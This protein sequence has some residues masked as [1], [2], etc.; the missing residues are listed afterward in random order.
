[1]PRRRRLPIA[2]LLGL[3]VS[4][5][6]AG[7]PLPISLTPLRAELE[8]AADFVYTAL[9]RQAGFLLQQVQPWETDPSLKL[10]TESRSGEHW[11][12]P[13][14]GT[15]VGL[16]AL[17]R[18][19][20][21]DAG[22]VGVD[23]DEVLTDYI[24]PMTRY[25]VAT[26][27]TG[28]RP[29]DDG[30]PWGD[31]W[32]SALWTH[33]LAR[34]A[35]FVWDDLP[36]DLRTGVRR[37]VAHE[38]DRFVEAAPPHALRYDTKAEENA[39]N[40]R[41][42]SAAVFLMPNDKRR[43]AWEQ[44]FE[45]WSMSSFLR[46]SDERCETLVEGKPVSD[47]F[48]GANV[49]E[50]FT[51]ENHGFVHPGYMGCIATTLG[52]AVDFRLSGRSAP[53]TIAWNAHELYDNLKWMATVDGNYV[54]PSGQDWTLFRNPQK[55][56]LHLMMAAFEGD[57]DGWSLAENSWDALRRMQART[58]EGRVFLDSEY[59][60][61]SMQHDTLS[62]L[63]VQWIAL[64]LADPIRDEPTAR[65]GVR[66]LPEG[67]I[68]LHR[69]ERAFVTLSYGARVMAQIAAMDRDRLVSPD[70]RSLI[71][72]VRVAGESEPAA[73]SVTRADVDTRPDGFTATL[74]VDH[75]PA[76]RAV[77]DLRSAADG[78]LF[79]EEVLT[80]SGDVTVENYATGLVGVLNNKQWVYEEGRRSV[81]IDGRRS[82]IEA[83]SGVRL[84]G[85]AS[86]IV[87][88][89]KLVIESERPLAVL[90]EAAAGPERGRATDRLFLNASEDE[91]RAYAAGE[92]ISRYA[93]VLRVR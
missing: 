45:R 42:L 19:G 30:E 50:D 32:Q 27:V 12:R 72:V 52:C 85:H 41:I 33:A 22:V 63:A 62:K 84:T 92:E 35:W 68:V 7:P 78:S 10:L 13:N 24:V 77:I 2:G 89:D 26:H 39:W 43:P 1:M 57:P 40:S 5:A 20:P 60:F 48:E 65:L 23:R 58:G 70:E 3:L 53:R 28:E 54:Y 11:I 66:H 75:G 61:P 67:K 79:V 51:C 91:P 31:H 6:V 80:A 34:A 15:L 76:V 16:A 86:E 46:P 55:A 38:A 9:M 18:W 90:Y 8:P 37:V 49:L 71:G 59:F 4:T 69:T 81:A 36:A 73:P 64:H 14:T 83:E 74:V 25:L 93:A 87:V 17:R 44:A 82:V 47:W 21:Y 29:T 88:D 56:S